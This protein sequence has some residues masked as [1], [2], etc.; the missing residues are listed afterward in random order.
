MACLIGVLA[1]LTTPTPALADAPPTG[2]AT[3]GEAKTP[4]T[5]IGRAGP[6]SLDTAGFFEAIAEARVLEQ[7]RAN[8]VPPVEAL[9]SADLRRRV[10]IKALETRVVRIE[11]ER[12]GLQPEPAEMTAALVNAARGRPFTSPVADPAPADL[13]ARLA[14]RYVSPIARVRS[15]AADLLG[16]RALAEALLDEVDDATHRARW[17]RD[18]TRITLDLLFVPR[19]PTSQE[20]EAT[21]KLRP[22]DIDI[23]Y[24]VNAA[25]Y[26]RPERARVRR[27]FAR[28]KDASPAALRAARARVE[29]W[30]SQLASGADLDTIMRLGDGPEAKRDGKVG[31]VTRAQNPAAFAAKEGGQTPPQREGVGADAGWAVY[32]VESILPGL[33]RPS[34]DAALRREIAAT[35]LREGDVL[36]NARQVAERT[37]ALLIA[38]PD[39]RTLQNWIKSNR[40]KRRETKPFPRSERT[41]VPGV[42]LAPAL[43]DAAFALRTP[44]AVT[45]VVRVRQDYVIARLVERDTPDPASWASVKAEYIEA[46]KRRSR[47]TIVED[48]LSSRLA[49]EPLWIDMPRIIAID[50]PGVGPAVEK[51]SR[52][53]GRSVG[54]P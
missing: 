3:A 15:V 2:D 10:V 51:R 21:V 22:D 24:A 33:E 30:A 36:P 40:V 25:R 35:L 27:L 50:V 26:V 5:R 6:A 41:L 28:A 19:V 54:V 39:S 37:R 49:G 16:A 46:W 17:L 23:W 20:I 11:V 53:G 9:A 12:R 13:D 52:A 38:R 34:H 45:P 18:S 4:E 32:H 1:G 29:G 47:S 44:G 42:G 48:W 31:R 14:A 8:R 43:V 7:W